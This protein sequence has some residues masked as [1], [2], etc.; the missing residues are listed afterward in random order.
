M[1]NVMKIDDLEQKL[2]FVQHYFGLHSNAAL[3]IRGLCK[4]SSYGAL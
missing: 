3:M 2:N 4:R 1:L